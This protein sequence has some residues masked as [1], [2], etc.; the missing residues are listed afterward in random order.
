LS[1][2]LATPIDELA[3]APPSR[4]L[5]SVLASGATLR[6]LRLRPLLLLTVHLEVDSL[7]ED[8]LV[9]RHRR[10]Q[11]DRDPGRG[12]PPARRAPRLHRAGGV[13][14]LGS[15]LHQ[16]AECFG[17]GV[18]PGLP[19]WLVQGTRHS[20]SDG[21]RRAHLASEPNFCRAST[22]VPTLTDEPA[23]LTVW[24]QL[25]ALWPSWLGTPPIGLRDRLALPEAGG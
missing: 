12:P 4:N 21:R 24:S 18:G 7:V 8:A 23:S 10:G 6:P 3:A 1:S 19:H 5:V 20:T 11:E 14:R 16:P 9:R 13:H 17:A 25:S 22:N 2:P 15:S